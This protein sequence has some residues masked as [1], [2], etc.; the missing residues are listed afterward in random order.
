[1]LNLASPTHSISTSLNPHPQV[2]IYTSASTIRPPP[3]TTTATV[4]FTLSHARPPPLFYYLSHSRL[5]STT[6]TA[7]AVQSHRVE[8]VPPS[9]AVD[10]H[11]HSLTCFHPVMAE[12]TRLK[13]L[14]VELK[15]LGQ[16]IEDVA[17]EHRAEQ[18]RAT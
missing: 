1:M 15:R 6:I 3:F 17:K 8:K 16:R 18:A 9:V 4:F 5:P 13:S 12:K 7:T 2:L 14:E 10:T 11:H